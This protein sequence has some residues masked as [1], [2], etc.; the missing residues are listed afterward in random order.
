MKTKHIFAKRILIVLSLLTL[1]L[2]GCDAKDRSHSAD[3]SA[4]DS[5]ASPVK[6]TRDNTPVC[7]VPEASGVTIYENELAHLDASNTSE[8]YVIVRYTGTSPK[9]KLQITGPDETTYTY[10]LNSE[11]PTDEV[12]P[13]QSG[14][15]D[16]L[17]NVYEN[18]EKNQYS[19]VF[20]QMVGANIENEFSPFLYPNQYVNF[21]DN[22]AAVSKGAELSFACNNDLE[23][24]SSIYNYIISNIEYDY[25]EA[26]T[27]Q[28][29]YIPDIDE[30]L[31]TQKGICLDYA[32]L[33]SSML[34]SQ[35][36]PTRM[37]VG[38]AGTAY[39]A[40]ISTY[41]EDIG[42]VN[43]IIEFDGTKWSLMDPTF[44]SNVKETELKN[45]IG[46]GSNY[47][48]KYIY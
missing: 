39:H 11:V 18:I 46:D 13:L 20:S 43:G 27:V 40:W 42:W 45:F 1:V 30:V 47:S 7:L 35:R 24:V 21:S 15:G 16:Y 2:F 19:M 3:V 26:E 9:V 25:E 4:E 23:V 5:P 34:R 44:A 33:M 28:S 6:G 8:G 31:S 32:V 38:Y 17:I 12:F 14:S 10:N 22:N 37:E 36:I 29:G 41:I 48:V